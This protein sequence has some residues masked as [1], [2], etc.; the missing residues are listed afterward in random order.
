MYITIDTKKI[1]YLRKGKG[2]PILFVH[3]WGGSM[4][5]LI[6]VFEM[7]AKHFDAII[8][9]L[10][11]FGKSD[12]PN[13]NWGII[14]Y[15]S[16]VNKLINKLNLGKIVYFGH[17]FGGSLGIY[18]S[19]QNP[20]IFS[21][22][23]LANSSFRRPKNKNNPITF[24]KRN[25]IARLPF[26]SKW[27]APVRYIFY[28]LFFRNSDL[29]KFP[30]LESNFRHI[31]T[32]DLTPILNNIRTKTLILWGSIDTYTPIRYAHELHEKIYRSKIKIFPDIGHNLPIKY[33]EIVYDEIKKFITKQTEH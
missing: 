30:K 16:V 24:I 32:H 25:L 23:I 28:K 21:H 3:G 5:S 33:P 18:L 4:K 12:P 27:E 7:A 13:T 19:A 20:N 26:Y 15:S 2:L 11:G 14:E 6:S 10:P 9:D 1:H 29:T 8:I 31:V 22:L 17:S